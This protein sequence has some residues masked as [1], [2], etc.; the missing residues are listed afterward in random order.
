MKEYKWNEHGVCTNPDKIIYNDEAYIEVAQRPSG[1]WSFGFNWNRKSIPLDYV[2]DVGFGC[3][4]TI[5][6]QKTEANT[7]EEAISRAKKVLDDRLTKIYG[8]KGG[9]M[10]LAF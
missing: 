2:G 3:P 5:D 6:W 9:Q 7:K 10:V 8:E 1:K 4:L